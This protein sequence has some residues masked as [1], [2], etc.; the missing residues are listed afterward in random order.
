MDFEGAPN[1]LHPGT[2]SGNSNAKRYCFS[3]RSRFA[4]RDEAAIVTNPA[5]EM[6]I[7]SFHCDLHLCRFRMTEDVRKGFLNNSQHRALPL[8]GQLIDFGSEL[9]AGFQ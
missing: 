8:V 3:A 6:R 4:D 5:L 7:R 2:H 9:E 1:L